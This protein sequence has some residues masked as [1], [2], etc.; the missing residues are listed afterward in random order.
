MHW[1]AAEAGDRHGVDAERA[2]TQS[3]DERHAVTS[4][5]QILAGPAVG[6]DVL[7]INQELK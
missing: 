5:W 6:S 2:R 3:T 1:A 7:Q 4:D